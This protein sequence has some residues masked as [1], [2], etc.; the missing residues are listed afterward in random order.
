MNNNIENKP[1]KEKKSKKKWIILLALLLIFI[2]FIVVFYP[3]LISKYFEY[4]QQNLINTWILDNAGLLPKNNPD[5][6]NQDDPNSSGNPN[7]N[8]P[9][10]FADEESLDEYVL[11]EDLNAFF[12]FNYALSKMTGTLKIPSI[13]LSL[14]ILKGDTKTNLNIGACEVKGSTILGTPGNYI[15][16][17][18]YSRVRG[19]FFNRL[20]DIQIGASVFIS[21]GFYSYE[22]EV[23]EIIHVKAED[24]WAVQLN[25]PE[26]IA[27]LITCD[28]GV[29]P[30]GRIIVKCLL[31]Q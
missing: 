26:R 4:R 22:Y 24:T 5:N 11:E 28:Y 18:H 25:V 20:P 9:P 13:N 15:L 17:G 6:Q 7:A 1:E 14:P 29:Q 2:G 16:A 12:D 8:V 19:R 30:Y 10:E 23:I 31:K 21:D 27:S 3:Y